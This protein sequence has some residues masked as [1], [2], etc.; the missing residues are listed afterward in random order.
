M[1][2]GDCKEKQ[3]RFAW[4][5]KESRRAKPGAA[6]FLLFNCAVRQSRK[7]IASDSGESLAI[8]FALD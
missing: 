7:E 8:L 1:R 6:P 3:R 2:E 4:Y 5:P